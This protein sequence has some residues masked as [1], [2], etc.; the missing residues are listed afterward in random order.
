[1][2]K[3]QKDDSWTLTIEYDQE[4]KERMTMSMKL[5]AAACR[6]PVHMK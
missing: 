3:K 2:K 5:T 4:K 1:M 6:T